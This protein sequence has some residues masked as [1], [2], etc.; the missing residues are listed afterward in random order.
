MSLRYYLRRPIFDTGAAYFVEQQ[1]QTLISLTDEAVRIIAA[2][3]RL[4]AADVEN[5]VAS[6]G[7]AMLKKDE[8][9]YEKAYEFGKLSVN[10][11]EVDLT[12]LNIQNIFNETIKNI[13]TDLNI[14]NTS[15]FTSARKAFTDASN[16][17]YMESY[18][19]VKTTYQATRDAV[20]T[21]ARDGITTVTYSGTR[22]NGQKWERNDHIDVAV[23]RN[24]ITTINQV[25]S[26][27]T[28]GRAEQ[29]GSDYVI[30]SKH[31]GE[32]PSHAEWSGKAYSLSGG[33]G[34]MEDGTTYGDFAV[35]G[36]GTAE[37]LCG[38]NCRHFFWSFIEGV[39]EAP[40]YA[41]MGYPTDKAEIERIYKDTQT[42]R[43]LERPT[44]KS[45]GIF[46]KKQKIIYAKEE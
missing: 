33:S 17:A 39:S 9:L 42:Q 3:A 8:A 2:N 46:E 41:K 34:T 5:M 21:M 25:N 27:M 44:I 28:L 4:A 10:P 13:K 30:V 7:I 19:G 11:K 38:I 12:R 16:R 18:S 14:T 6:S 1:T 43:R 37:G 36:Y 32:R 22:E 31:R 29:L 15:A 35:T 45:Q 24:T 23:R 40:D 20:V 26:R